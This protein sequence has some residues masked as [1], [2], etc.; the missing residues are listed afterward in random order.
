MKAGDWRHENEQFQFGEFKT[1]I[2][3]NFQL[4]EDILLDFRYETYQVRP[5]GSV[6]KRIV[7]LEDN[8][9]LEGKQITNREGVERNLTLND[10]QLKRKTSKGGA[11]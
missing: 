8:D 5:D 11:S 6:T 7:D 9:V 10:I 3:D 2:I 4:D 1:E